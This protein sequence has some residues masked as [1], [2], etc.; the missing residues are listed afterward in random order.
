MKHAYLILSHKND[1]TVKSLLKLLDYPENDIYVHMDLKETQYCENDFTSILHNSKIFFTK[2]TSV[3]WGGYSLINATLELLELAIRSD[4]Q[5]SYYHLLSGQDLPLKSQE[6][7]HQFFELNNGF[8]FVDFQ[9]PS[10]TFQK[11]IRYY[12]FFQ[13]KIGRSL[14]IQYRALNCVA[15]LF[16]KIFRINRN[17][18]IRFQKGCNWFSITNELAE[19]VIGNKDFIEKIFKYTCNADEIFLQTLIINSSFKNKLFNPTEYNSGRMNLRLI[20]WERGKPY[21]YTIDDF[22]LLTNSPLLF[23]R[24][25]DCKKDNLIIDKISEYVNNH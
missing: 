15:I 16:Q 17:K 12:Y 20:D 5:Y 23:A 11:R 3:T 1:Y 10:F 7:I 6:Y 25:F 21:T 14:K 4:E 19:Y 8:E 18:N 22:E 2:R 24:K 9:S 13:E